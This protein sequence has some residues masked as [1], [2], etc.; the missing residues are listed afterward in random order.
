MKKQILLTLFFIFT[1]TLI[2]Q[3]DLLELLEETT[4][5]EYTSST[6]KDTK[7]INL[8]SNESPAK[9]QLQFII[10]NVNVIIEVD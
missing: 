4:E 5:T 8:Q 3:D 7:I 1:N 9:G 6:F 2:A 10:F